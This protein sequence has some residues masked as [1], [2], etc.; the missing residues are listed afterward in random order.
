MEKQDDMSI[1]VLEYFRSVFDGSN[2]SNPRGVNDEAGIITDEQNAKL[3]AEINFKEFITAVQQ[4]HPDKSSG[5]DGFSPAFFQHIWDLLG[6][7]VFHCCKNW[8][9]E[10]SFPEN[11]NDTTI[12]LITQKE[13][14][15]RMTELRPIALCNVLYKILAKVL[16]NRLKVILPGVITENQSA[17]VPGRNI[18]DNVLVAFEILHFMK[19]KNRGQEG[20]VALKL[21]ISKAYNRVNWNFL[22]NTMK[23][24]GFNE[25]WINW[26]M[27]CVSTVSYSINLNGNLIGPITPRRGL[28][29][30]DPL[31]PYLFCFV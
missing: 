26:M 24:L 19:R 16:E 14:A 11:L 9:S 25:T 23:M 5:P 22:K 15:E 13:N 27:L 17:F 21:D 28:R 1:V 31:S 2:S 8:L 4:M 10:C 29:K 30:G 3:T 7:E 20:E 12:V 18:A 6:E